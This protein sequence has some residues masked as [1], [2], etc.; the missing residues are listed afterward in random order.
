MYRVIKISSCIF[1]LLFSACSLRV[2]VKVSEEKLSREIPVSG[3]PYL[4]MIRALDSFQLDANIRLRPGHFIL[5][6]VARAK[7]VKIEIPEN[8]DLHVFIV[9][10]VDKEYENI[11][12]NNIRNLTGIRPVIK[13]AIIT[14]N[15]PIPVRTSGLRFDFNGL[16]YENQ[17]LTAE[18]ALK[19]DIISLFLSPAVGIPIDQINREVAMSMIEEIKITSMK[20]NFT[21]GETLSFEGIRLVPGTRSAVEFKDVIFI[22]DAHVSGKLSLNL[23]ADYFHWSG[24]VYSLRGDKGSNLIVHDL[25]FSYQ[26]GIFTIKGEDDLFRLNF[27]GSFT[28]GIG[29]LQIGSPSYLLLKKI[30]ARYEKGKIPQIDA[31]LESRW[32]IIKGGLNLPDVRLTLDNSTLEINHASLEQD[33]TLTL[34]SIKDTFLNARLNFVAAKKKDLLDLINREIQGNLKSP[35]MSFKAKEVYIPAQNYRIEAF[36]LELENWKKIRQ[37]GGRFLL[38]VESGPLADF[39]MGLDVADGVTLSAVLELD[40][41]MVPLLFEYDGKQSRFDGQTGFEAGATLII[42]ESMKVYTDKF[43]PRFPKLPG[44]LQSL[45]GARLTITVLPSDLSLKA[46]AEVAKIGHEYYLKLRKLTFSGN[47]NTELDIGNAVSMSMSVPFGID[48]MYAVSVLGKLIDLQE[49]I[50]I[51]GG[52]LTAPFLSLEGLSIPL[53]TIF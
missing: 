42:K 34:L 31:D 7:K 22:D 21:P 17:T 33:E 23:T 52:L 8:L 3:N 6:E 1:L 39:E 20:G 14:P 45:L 38:K 49:I 36:S 48:A 44:R 30:N 37:A 4:Q 41:L 53:G 5:P 35:V 18:L 9:I 28:S 11:T 32:S 19:L 10:D 13:K 24:D 51:E 16:N 26:E 25:G 2:N 47:L 50:K 46:K 27:A 40:E 12:Q 29:E 43:R 15:K